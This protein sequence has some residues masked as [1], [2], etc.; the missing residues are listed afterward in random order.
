MRLLNTARALFGVA[1]AM[2]LAT[3]PA[4]AQ[5]TS[6]TITGR[7]IDNQ[8]LALPGVTVTVESPNRPGA[9]SVTTPAIAY[10]HLPSLTHAP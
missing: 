5:T 8:H 1:L 3:A 6:G 7:V 9:L 2:L 4:S 10:S